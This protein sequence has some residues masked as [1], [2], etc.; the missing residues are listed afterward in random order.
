[1]KTSNER[2]NYEGVKAFLVARVS[3]P[4]Q[5]EALPAQEIR[6]EEY[7]KQLKLNAEL[8]SFDETAFKE[9]RVKFVEIVDKASKYPDSFIMVFDK[10]DR[11][12]RDVSSD[13][14]RTLKNL[15]KEGRAELHFPSDGLVFHKNSPAH[16]KT[17]LDM[18]MVF[19][20]Y[21]SAAI[22][23]NVKRKIELKLSRGEYPGKSCI[24]YT[25]IKFMVDGE[26]RKNIIPDPERKD[27]IIKAFELRLEAKS[28]RSIAKILRN[29]GLRSNTAKHGI[30]GQSQI[31]T[32]LRNPFYYGRMNFGGS[33][34]D[35]KY[36]P[37]IS[38]QMFDMV[39]RVNEVR[40]NDRGKTDTKKHFTF[41]GL[42]KCA[43]CGCSISSYEQKGHVYM[44]C[45]KAKNIPCNQ[46]HVSEAEIMP[47]INQLLDSLRI[48][49]SIVNQVVDVLKV[50]HDN[51]QTFY[52]NAITQT[53]AEYNRLQK[54]LDTLYEDRLDGRITVADYDKYVNKYK[55]EMDE[56]DRK[57]VEFTN[58]DKSFVV[59][60][61]YL[62]RLASRAK[63]LFESSQ[64]EQK[65]KILRMLLANLTLNQKRLQLYLLKP[66]KDLLL[67][68]KS[69]NWL[70]QLDSNQV[71]L[72]PELGS[73]HTSLHLLVCVV[74]P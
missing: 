22:S 9:D 27:Y 34:Y 73:L 5:R 8:F 44:R 37:I 26:E 41:N 25:N 39:Q 40:T 24:G 64:P 57:L 15:V 54:K 59:T 21:Y 52:K 74:L 46:P 32:M 2:T 11:L 1:M 69:Q 61:E 28:Y 50:E 36:E 13:V 53:R 6:L 58:N 67:D 20:G 17:R 10:I 19:G 43:N 31:E 72:P 51:I 4:S 68:T 18:G 70:P 60:A 55:A 29:E 45:T 33:Q 63:E 47:Q 12:T 35:H 42:L 48:S 16:D 65:N 23:D 56:L 14:V 7:A 62:L 49:E 66:F 30:V 38:K 71:I 3:D